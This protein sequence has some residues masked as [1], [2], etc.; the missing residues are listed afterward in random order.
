MLCVT[1]EPALAACASNSR[2]APAASKFTMTAAVPSNG[3]GNGLRGM[4]ERVEMLGGTLNRSTRIGHD[5]HHY[6]AVER[7]RA[8]EG[9]AARIESV[10]RESG[11]ESGRESGKEG[12]KTIRV[13]LAEDQGMVL[14]A[15]AAL[16]EIEGDISVVAKAA[17]GKEALR[18]RACAQAR[19]VHHRH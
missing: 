13:V 6:S 10:N 4:R 9:K 14:G 15:L 16:L 18:G 2:T 8:A 1:R 3:E 11:K 5:A 17:N 12:R 7:G 19:R